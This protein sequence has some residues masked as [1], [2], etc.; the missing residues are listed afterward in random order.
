MHT[1]NTSREFQSNSHLRRMQTRLPAAS[2]FGGCGTWDHNQNIRFRLRSGQCGETKKTQKGG[3]EPVRDTSTCTCFLREQRE[4]E[5]DLILKLKT[6]VK[7]I[8]RSMGT[9]SNE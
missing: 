4:R 6:Q 3:A 7:T 8:L 1:R 5:V 2:S 9:K